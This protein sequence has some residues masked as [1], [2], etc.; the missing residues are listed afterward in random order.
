METFVYVIRNPR[1]QKY[2]IFSK[3]CFGMRFALYL[4]SGNTRV[5]L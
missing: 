3:L 2:N 1:K 4:G 5:Y